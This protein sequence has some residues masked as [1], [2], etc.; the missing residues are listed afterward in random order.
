MKRQSKPY[1]MMEAM[2]LAHSLPEPVREFKFHPTRNWR[3]DFAWPKTSVLDGH[4]YGVALEIDGGAWTRG[5]HTRGKGFIADM[6]KLNEAQLLEWVV[7]RCTPADIKS[8]A[9]FALLRRALA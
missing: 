3:F 8:G 1:P 9:A 2:C 5:R 6:E 7:L 4:Y